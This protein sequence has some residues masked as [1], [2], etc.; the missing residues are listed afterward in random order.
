MCEDQGRVTA[1]D[2]IDHIIPLSKGGPDTDENTRGLCL[3]HHDEVTG[4]I[5]S[6][7]MVRQD[8]WGV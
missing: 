5:F 4:K 8:G 2:H 1:T 6:K 3:K 7:R